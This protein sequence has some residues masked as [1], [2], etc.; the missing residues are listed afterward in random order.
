[1]NG[2]YTLEYEDIDE[3]LSIV[4]TIIYVEVWG[5]AKDLR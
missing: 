3:S 1:M 4:C 5:N 2:F